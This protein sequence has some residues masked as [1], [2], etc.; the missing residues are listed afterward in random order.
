M[1]VETYT[2]IREKVGPHYPVLIKINSE[3]YMDQGMTFEECKYVCQKLVELGVNAI[4]VSGG[5][6]SSR[7]NEGPSII[8]RLLESRGG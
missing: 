5:S 1:V 2:A 4:K 8:Y 3:D 6:F 7:R